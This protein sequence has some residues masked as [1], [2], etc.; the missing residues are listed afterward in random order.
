MF[1]LRHL[2]QMFASDMTHVFKDKG[3]LNRIIKNHPLALGT[4]S[5]K[6]SSFLQILSLSKERFYCLQGI[7]VTTGDW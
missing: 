4:F 7:A 2:R 3:N 6:C 1:G 5:L